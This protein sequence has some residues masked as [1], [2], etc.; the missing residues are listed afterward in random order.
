MTVVAADPRGLMGAAAQVQVVADQVAAAVA[1]RRR[2]LA[3]PG[4]RGWQS[5][6]ELDAAATAWAE[7]LGELAVGLGE[8][9]ADLRVVAQTHETADELAAAAWRVEPLR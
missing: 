5:A 3:V 7:R 6:V 2:G 4:Q 8:L 1:M 9:A